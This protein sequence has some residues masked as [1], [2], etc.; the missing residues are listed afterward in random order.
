MKIIVQEFGAATIAIL[1]AVL[2]L[3][4]LF[5][6]SVSGKS[7][8]LGIAGTAMEKGE[9]DY[10]SY[11]DFD[12]VVTWHNRAKPEAAYTAA[13]GRFY[14]SENANFLVRYYARDM[15]GVIYLMDKV[16]LARLFPDM[17][18]GKILDIRKADGSSVMGYYSAP[19]GSVRFP[20]A[21]VYLVYFQI[22]DRENLTSV[23]KIPVA[24]DERRN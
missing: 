9:V 20:G 17:M 5:G 19:D 10:T 16:I 8:I 22:R 4:I 11:N 23:W 3:G 12:A 7:G 18:Y 1:T 21:G 6:M 24:V 2:L 15:E 13:F 14:A